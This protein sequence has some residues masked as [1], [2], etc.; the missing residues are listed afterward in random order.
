MGYMNNQTR[1][2]MW[3]VAVLAGSLKPDESITREELIKAL[4][5][6]LPDARQRPSDGEIQH[7][8]HH[9]IVNGGV[10]DAEQLVSYSVAAALSGR[11]IQAI[12]QAAHR[13]ILTKLTVYRDGRQHTAIVLRTLADWCRWTQDYFENRARLADELRKE[14]GFPKW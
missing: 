11:S 9:F 3:N 4:R 10:H 1:Q 6:P 2:A 14:S 7:T 12:R 13:G 8:Y 5:S